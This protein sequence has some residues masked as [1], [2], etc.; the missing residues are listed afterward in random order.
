MKTII[1]NA[2]E[3]LDLI[4]AFTHRDQYA[5]CFNSPES[6]AAHIEGRAAAGDSWYQDYYEAGSVQFRQSASLQEAA[7]LCR[8]GWPD[9]ARRVSEL[10]DKINAANPMGPRLI[11]WSVAGAYPSIPRYLAGDPL[12][13]RQLDSAKLRRRPVMTI[14]SGCGANGNVDVKSLTRRAAVTAAIVDVIEAA[15]FSCA[16]YVAAFASSGNL[17]GGAMVTVKDAGQQ[18]DI[19]RMAFAMGH[20]AFFRRF[21]FGALGNNA[22]TKPL[23]FGLGTQCKIDASKMPA[24]A[25][26]IP[27]LDSALQYKFATDDL[28]A[29]VGLQWLTA[30]LR[31]QDC[32]AFPKDVSHAAA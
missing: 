32:P 3:L 20:G 14:V 26:Y 1:G 10:R 17:V 13:M 11:K 27:E 15:G 21:V 9:G 31:K 6:F 5:E 23:G 8:N 4:P 19:G 16:V 30:E 29:T 24:G 28:A 7:D 12:H 22:A 2:P 18:V 25:Y